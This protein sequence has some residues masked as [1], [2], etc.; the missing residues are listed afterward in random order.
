MLA[1]ESLL[2]APRQERSRRNREAL[3][4]AALGAFAESGYDTSTIDEIARRAGVPVGGFYLHFRSKR[5]ALLVLMDRLLGE[6]ERLEPVLGGDAKAAIATLVREALRVDIAYLGAYRAW[7]EAVLR[8]DELAILHE[9]IDIWTTAR[10]ALLIEAVGAAPNARRDVEPAVLARILNT[11]FWRL[12]ELRA[13]DQAAIL[14]TVTALVV[15][16]IFVDDP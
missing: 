15:H 7:H 16:A 10:I 6:L 11:L 4:D 1:G 14:H 3:L 9:S 12:T 5:Q 8:D 13:G 2:P